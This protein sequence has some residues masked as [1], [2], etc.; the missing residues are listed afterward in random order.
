MKFKLKVNQNGTT[1]T[2]TNPLFKSDSFK[3]GCVYFWHSAN[4]LFSAVAWKDNRVMV[5]HIAP[6]TTV[7]IKYAAYIA[8]LSN[9]N[10]FSIKYKTNVI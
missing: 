10:P 1:K 7:Y 8:Y 9:I 4:N 3:R 2:I 6:F 5:Q